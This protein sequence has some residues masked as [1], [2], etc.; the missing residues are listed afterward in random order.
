[1]Q[2][3]IRCKKQLA[4][5]KETALKIALAAS[6]GF[7]G[8]WISVA[9]KEGNWHISASSKSDA[10]PVYFVVNG[11]TAKLV[12][13]NFNTDVKKVPKKFFEIPATEA[14]NVKESEGKTVWEKTS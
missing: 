8:T 11:K 5:S 12:Y 9:L 10:A 2:K 4:V 3:K 13:K 1:M 6:G 14:F 7:L